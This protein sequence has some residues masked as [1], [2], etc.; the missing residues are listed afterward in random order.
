VA[1]GAAVGGDVG[2]AVAGGVAAAVETAVGE[3]PPWGVPAVGGVSTLVGRGVVSTER[4][5]TA[6]GRGVAVGG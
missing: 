1:V 5:T 6:A 2:F 3:A 4:S